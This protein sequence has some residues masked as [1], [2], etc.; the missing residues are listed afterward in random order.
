MYL[1]LGMDTVVPKKEIIGIFDTDNATSS[2]I[3]RDFLAAAE[4]GGE[5]VDIS[6]DLPK[7]FILCERAGERKVYLS[8]LSAQTLLRRSTNELP[9]EF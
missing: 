5:I 7:S 6:G 4:R 8:Q 1:H 3:T 2:K 9:G